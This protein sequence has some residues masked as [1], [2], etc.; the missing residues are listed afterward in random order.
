MTPRH[1]LTLTSLTLTATAALA[2]CSPAPDLSGRTFVALD[3]TGERLVDG[4]RVV[5]AFREDA[6]GAQPGCNSMSAP[7]TWDD[8]VLRLT[9]GL[10]STRMAC[11]DE[12]MAQD[13][14]FAALLA[15]SPTLDLQDGVLTLGGEDVTVTLVEEAAE[16]S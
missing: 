15:A 11:T 3:A 2:A 16:E 5:L 14:W 10:T 1:A 12:L 6:V 4:S 9:G 13:D 7:A 8:G